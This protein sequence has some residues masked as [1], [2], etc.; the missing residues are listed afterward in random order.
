MSIKQFLKDWT[1]PVAIATGTVVYLIFYWVPQLEPAS[2]FFGPII[3][4]IFPMMVFCTLFST[5]SAQCVD[6]LLCRGQPLAEDP[7]GER[8]HL[9][10]RSRSDGSP[11]GDR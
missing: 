7:L 3:D 5:R 10:H 4:T 11:S 6:H 1:L 2:N 9:Y 8:A